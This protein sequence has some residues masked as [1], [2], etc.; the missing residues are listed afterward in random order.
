VPK[1]PDH[2]ISVSFF[3]ILS[4]DQRA[5]LAAAA[6]PRTFGPG[7]FLF[8]EG[9][10]CQGLYVLTS[11]AVKIIKT[12]PSGR[13]I[14]L[15]IE[16]APSTVA[17][18]PVFDGGAYPAT[19]QAIEETQVLLILKRDFTELC[20]RSPGLALKFLEVFGRRLRQLVGLVELVTFGSVRQRL[21]RMLLE[22][23][24]GARMEA[25]ALP[26]THEELASRLGTVREVVT[27][28]LSRFQAEGFVRVQRR[29]IEVL[30][31]QGLEAE[32]NTEL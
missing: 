30:D 12:T 4:P 9:E 16:A 19:V 18:V 1:T 32:A 6:I 22:F 21:A 3:A 10:P 11:G 23:A 8:H 24:E 14:L 7:E 17:E 5:S 20:H 2:L 31:R 28:N 29:E 25:F 27:R 13:Q 26:A 15:G